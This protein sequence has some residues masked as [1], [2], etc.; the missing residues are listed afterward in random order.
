VKLANWRIWPH[1]MISLLGIAPTAALSTYGPTIVKSLGFSTVQ[2]NAYS[3]VGPW[4]A[5]VFNLLS[6]F[7]S[8]F[9]GHPVA[10]ILPLSTWYLGSMVSATTAARVTMRRFSF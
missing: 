2:A 7:L 5:I 10:A 9:T 3:S 8:A 6:G 1:V 4:I